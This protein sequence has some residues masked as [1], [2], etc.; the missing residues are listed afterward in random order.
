MNFYCW[1]LILFFLM[2]VESSLTLICIFLITTNGIEHLFM[3]LLAILIF[4]LVKCLWN[5][6]P[7][8]LFGRPSFLINW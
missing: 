8:F 7:I 1:S 2:G 3:F 6:L 4:F 5:L